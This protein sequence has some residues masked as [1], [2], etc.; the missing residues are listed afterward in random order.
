MVV[1]VVIKSGSIYVKN[2]HQTTMTMY[3]TFTRGTLALEIETI[4][5]TRFKLHG[6]KTRSIRVTFLS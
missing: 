2:H 1:Y 3:Y 6:Y 5:Q 4:D